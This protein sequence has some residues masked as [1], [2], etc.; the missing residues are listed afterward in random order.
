MTA[1]DTKTY[2]ASDIAKM[3]ATGDHAPTTK[4][5]KEAGPELDRAFWENARVVMPGESPK[6]P[7]SMRLDPE[8]LAWFKQSGKGYLSRMNAVL[9]AYVEA[10]KPPHG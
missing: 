6:V 4:R 7:I 3:V 5:A 8:V 9:R 1:S 2:S 10:Q